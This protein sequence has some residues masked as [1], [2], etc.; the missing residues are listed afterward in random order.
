MT[1]GIPND[2]EKREARRRKLEELNR[3]KAQDPEFRIRLKIAAKKRSQDPEWRRKNKEHREKMYKDPEWLD[4][5]TKS[6]RKTTQD[7][8][9][10]RKHKEG[11]EKRSLNPKWR[12]N[13]K[14]GAKKRSLDPEWQRKNKEHREKMYQDPE[15]QRNHMESMQKLA[16]DPEWQRKQREGAQKNA[17]DPQWLLKQ[18]EWKVGGFWY[19]NVDNDPN[20]IY[21]EDWKDVNPLVH[22]FFHDECCL[23]HAPENGRS[24]IGHHVF[25]VKDH[26]K[27]SCCSVSEDGIYHTNLNAS[28]HPEH[29]YIIGENP[30][31]FVIL[32]PSCHGR[33]NGKFANR[34]KWAD[35]FRKMV[36]E[37][38]DGMCYLPKEELNIF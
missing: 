15:W 13:V 37:E 26:E 8:E 32:C 25:Y 7:P 12:R 2:P 24:H 34:K 6:N 18:Q 27:D 17:Q 1:R 29:D 33:T 19:G 21:H 35:Y 20:P 14:K 5:I 31:Y 9:Y 4:T 10:K 11:I 36:D 16:Q 28:D 23:C 3:K 30:N 22:T 38:Y